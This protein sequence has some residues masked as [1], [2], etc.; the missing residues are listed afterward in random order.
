MLTFLAINVAESSGSTEAEKYFGL[1]GQLGL[2]P[3][4]VTQVTQLRLTTDSKGYGS[5][6]QKANE[7]GEPVFL[8]LEDGSLPQEFVANIDL[9][10]GVRA[11]VNTVVIW[12]ICPTGMGDTVGFLIMGLNPH[13]RLD[14]N[15]KSF[16][17]IMKR[18]IATS[19]AAILLF[20][21]EVRHRNHV[22]QQLDLRTKELLKSEV[23]FQRIADSSMVGIVTADPHGN[24]IYANQAFREI[25]G[26]GGTDS[27][28]GSWLEL[29]PENAAMTLREVW[30]QLYATREPIVEEYPLNK[31]W[32]KVLRSGEVLKGSTWILVSAFI[33]EDD[34]GVIKGSLATVT[35]I[36]QQKWAEEHQKRQMEEAMVGDTILHIENS[37]T[38]DISGT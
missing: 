2:P 1:E 3:D 23:K 27:S 31:P 13:L 34:N 32:T 36:S 12:P 26:H 21:D 30:K 15:F 7:T 35:D 29:F 14:D 16:L 4:H 8:S 18:Q 28:M 33:E 24:I 20:E 9:R 5:A 38:I 22:A 25:T 17:D 19:A 10:G 11:P 6:M 37:L